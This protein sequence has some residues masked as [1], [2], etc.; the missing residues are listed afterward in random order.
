[1][2]RSVIRRSSPTSS[3]ISPTASRSTTAL[4]LN[5]ALPLYSNHSVFPNS[6]NQM[7]FGSSFWCPF[8][9][10][11]LHSFNVHSFIRYHPFPISSN[12][13]PTDNR[14]TTER[15][16]THKNRLPNQKSLIFLAYIKNFS[17]LCTRFYIMR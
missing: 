15:R 3:A 1:M 12:S 16:P 7:G 14:H 8:I 13:P 17:Y 11:F 10:S 5:G 9:R 4:I 6:S 2:L